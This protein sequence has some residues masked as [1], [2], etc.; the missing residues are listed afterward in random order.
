MDTVSLLNSFLS[1]FRKGVY[2]KR[3]ELAPKGHLQ[4]GPGVQKSKQEITKVMSLEQ[5]I[6]KSALYI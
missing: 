6:R 1:P 4:S 3:K 5:N 2:S